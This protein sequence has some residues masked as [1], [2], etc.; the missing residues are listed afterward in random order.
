MM[1]PLVLLKVLRTPLLVAVLGLPVLLNP[2]LK[3]NFWIWLQDVMP[4]S[5]G[6]NLWVLRLDYLCYLPNVAVYLAY[7]LGTFMLIELKRL[8]ARQP[9]SGRAELA[10]MVVALILASSVLWWMRNVKPGTFQ[11]LF[12]IGQVLLLWVGFL[13]NAGLSGVERFAA[14]PAVTRLLEW[15]FP[16]SD[17]LCYRLH[18]QRVRAAGAVRWLPISCVVGVLTLMF[19]AEGRILHRAIRAERINVP[20]DDAQWAQPT[21]GGFWFTNGEFLDSRAGIWFYDERTRQGYPVIRTSDC[22][23]FYFDGTYLY[24]EDRYDSYVRKINP[25][26]KELLWEVPIIRTGTYQVTGRDGMIFAAGEGGHILA[27]DSQGHV[28]A[29]RTFSPLGTWVPQAVWGGQ[30]AFLSGDQRVH[31]WKGDLTHGDVVTIPLPKGVRPFIW[32]SMEGRMRSILNWTDYVR[33]TETLY[34]QSLWGE[35]FRYDVKHRQWLSSLK[36]PPGLRSITA[37]HRNGLVFAW[38]YY[39]GYMSVL[40]EETG[41]VVGYVLANALNRYIN[42]DPERMVG[43]ASTHGYGVWRFDYGELVRRRKAM[44]LARAGAVS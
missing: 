18:Q 10:M 17:V 42:L 8:M 34:I 23:Q 32:N 25:K 1:R 5:I 36:A 21:E 33:E 9:Q 22:R 38:N 7:L 26:T 19:A 37:D 6:L 14:K 44:H 3:I 16:V 40:D 12:S 24:Y 30:V 20:V 4:W 15:T 2:A 39:Q 29:Q 11:L 35:I 27:V 43:I 28:K 31:I 13:C 41:E